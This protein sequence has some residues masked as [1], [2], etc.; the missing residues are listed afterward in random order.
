[1]VIL[2]FQGWG[3]WGGL[4]GGMRVRGLPNSLEGGGVVCVKCTIPWDKPG[5][6]ELVSSSCIVWWDHDLLLYLPIG[7]T[8]TPHF[9]IL[10]RGHTVP[11]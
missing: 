5:T 6:P 2:L 3:G 10:V 9:Y 8:G 4:Y 1:M 11:S 7:H